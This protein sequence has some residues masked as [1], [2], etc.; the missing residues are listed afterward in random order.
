MAL[1]RRLATTKERLK[2]FA[3]N[4]SFST[5]GGSA[6]NITP[7][8]QNNKAFITRKIAISS[9]KHAKSGLTEQRHRPSD[10]F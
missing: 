5:N 7:K 10:H 8:L 1:L 4:V 3:L 6:H 2:T 9:T